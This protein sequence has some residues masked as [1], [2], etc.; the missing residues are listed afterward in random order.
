MKTPREYTL[1]IE[2]LSHD[3]QGIASIDGKRCFV[4]Q[5][6]PQ[7]QVKV[8]IVQDK[9]RYFIAKLESVI[10]PSAS[11]V[12]PQCP[13]FGVC[14]G[15]QLQHMSQADQIQLKQNALAEQLQHFG[16]TQPQEWLPPL[17]AEPYGYRRKARIGVR[18]VHKKEKLLLGFREQNGRYLADC[19][20]CHV[21]HPD[22]AK[23]WQ[24]LREM[25]ATL[26]VYQEIPQVEVAV[27]DDA[28]ALVLRHL[29][30][31]NDDDILA[32][33][34]FAKQYNVHFYLQPK[35]PDTV[36]RIWPVDGPQ[37]LHYTLTE[38][39]LKFEFHPNDFTQINAGINQQM[40]SQAMKLLDLQPSDTALDLFCGLGNFTL[41]LAQQAHRVVGVEGDEA[42]VKRVLENAQANQLDNVTAYC[43][44]LAEDC[45]DAPWAK[46]PYDK[47]LLD[48]PRTGAQTLIPLLGKLGAS[49]IVYIS[50]NPATLARDAGLLKEQGY[51]LEKAGIMDM[52]THT[53]HTEAMALFIK[54]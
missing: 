28:I 47:I 4:P 7:E 52:F 34:N 26:S 9:R 3:G 48:P 33:T 12:A 45:M 41:P 38:Q 35:G 20:T 32:C 18:Y 30:A 5:V 36:H 22:V 46:Q 2:A 27:G 49:R 29:Q 44:N 43:A 14:G 17:K 1:T 24:P 16:H 6:L 10:T 54:V 23:L 39:K 21:I 11:R 42:M 15:C 37:R 19:D 53:Q 40:V 8:H 25:I 50:C 51:L 13:H 31:L